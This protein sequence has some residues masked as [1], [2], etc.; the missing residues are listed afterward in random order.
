M[1]RCWSCGAVQPQT[2]GELVRGWRGE[3]DVRT[4][5]EEVGVSAAT[6]SRVERGEL[7]DMRTFV[8]LVQATGVAPAFAVEL[9][10]KQVATADDKTVAAVGGDNATVQAADAR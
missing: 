7:P 4:A 10:R 2:F 9:I 8:M 1:E 3:K 5:G 6:I